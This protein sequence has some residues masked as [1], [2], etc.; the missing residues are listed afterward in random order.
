MPCAR[1]IPFCIVDFPPHQLVLALGELPI[2]A[3]VPDSAVIKVLVFAVT[4]LACS[5][6]KTSNPVGSPVSG[7]K[8]VGILSIAIACTPIAIPVKASPIPCTE[9]IPSATGL[10]S[11]PPN[12]EA[13]SPFLP[14][15]GNLIC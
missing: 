7:S 2:C 14:P 4:V 1:S 3:K 12:I 9:E 5:K 15:P 8:P 10:D 6:L 13:K 11:P